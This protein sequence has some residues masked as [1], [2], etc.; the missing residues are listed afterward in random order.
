MVGVVGTAA[1]LFTTLSRANVNIIFLTQGSSEQSICFGVMPIDTESAI[2][3]VNSDF[4]SE[5]EAN[6]YK[7]TS[8]RKRANGDCCSW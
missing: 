4:A 8:S 3:A 6:F 7:S 5:I 1:R 2:R